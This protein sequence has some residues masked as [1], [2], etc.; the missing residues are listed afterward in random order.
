L[1]GKEILQIL[2]RCGKKH[3]SD[4]GTR[5]QRTRSDVQAFKPARETRALPGVMR[6]IAAVFVNAF[7]DRILVEPVVLSA[8]ARRHLPD[9][10]SD[11]G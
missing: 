2:R 11:R 3:L 5:L 4:K 6:Y 10:V 1:G 9:R 8:R 7:R